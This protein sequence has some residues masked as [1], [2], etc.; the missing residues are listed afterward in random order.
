MDIGARSVTISRIRVKFDNEAPGLY[1]ALVVG[2]ALLVTRNPRL[3]A[4]LPV[5]MQEKMLND[6][7]R[8]A[9]SPPR[10]V[11]DDD[12]ENVIDLAAVPAWVAYLSRA[13]IVPE[14]RD[15]EHPAERP[16]R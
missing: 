4:W 13:T 3:S 1:S 10:Q 6:V 9:V 11:K 8:E 15:A 5:W 14:P 2:D 7:L 12:S 16:G